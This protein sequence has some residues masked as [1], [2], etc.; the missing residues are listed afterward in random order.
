MCDA[1]MDCVYRVFPRIRRTTS[2]LLCAPYF[3][4]LRARRD[5][6]LDQGVICERRWEECFVVVGNVIAFPPCVAG[7]RV[8][9]CYHAALHH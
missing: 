4:G 5:C 8:R 7:V 6:L 9:S 1:M 3:G 2:A